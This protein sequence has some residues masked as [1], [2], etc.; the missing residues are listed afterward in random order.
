MGKYFG[1]DGFRGVAGEELLSTHAYKIGRFLGWYFKKSGK[2]PRA[3][4]GKDTRLS[5][6][7][8]EYSLAS[9]LSASGADVYMLHV[10]TT[11]S[12]SYTVH[13]DGFDIGIMISASHNPFYDNGIKIINSNGEKIDDELIEKIE[14]YIDKEETDTNML[15]FASGK[16]VGKITDYSEGRNRYIAYLI[17]S[18]KRSFKGLKIGIDPSNGGAFMISRAVFDALGAKTY[19][20]NNE[21]NGTNINKG[22]GSTHISALSDFVKLNSLDM[23]FAYDGDADRCIAVDSN[24]EVVDGDK[25]LYIL[26]KNLKNQRELNGSTIVTTI[27]SNSGL[28][29]ALQEIG[30]NYKETKVGDRFVYEE[31][32]RGGYSLG[33]EQSGHIIISKYAQTGD[34][35][36]TSIKLV[37]CLLE[38]KTTLSKL[39][40]EVVLYPQVL[41]NAHVVD[42]NAVLSSPIVKEAHEKAHNELSKKGGR[43]LLRPSGTEPLIRIL[44]ECE[45]ESD[46]ERIAKELMEAIEKA[47]KGLGGAE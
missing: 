23:G 3:V 14:E 36:L 44:T 24:G 13:H 18:S 25:I 42:K 10:T 1:T 2:R 28:Y 35:I 16:D 30:I 7:M 46:C 34:G 27:M 39:A 5:S 26:A 45:S 19:L 20:I 32:Q 40:S 12:V 15:P 41:K 33:G 8:L 43:V 17:S 29:S 11:P 38:E 47:N 22:C 6:Y 21:P 4:V 9:G 37:E 31:M